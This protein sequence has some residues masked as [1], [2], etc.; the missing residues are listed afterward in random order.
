V[1]LLI[2]RNL[3]LYWKIISGS[4]NLDG[5]LR[6]CFRNRSGA[7]QSTWISRH[8]QQYDSIETRPSPES[9]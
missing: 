5:W 7:L 9:S 4:Y 1:I 6:Y 2:L 3:Q 8:G